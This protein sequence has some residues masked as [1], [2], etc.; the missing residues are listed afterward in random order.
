MNDSYDL[1][2]LGTP[3]QAYEKLD[4]LAKELQQKEQEAKKFNELE[5]LFELQISKYPE[6]GETKT[7]LRY[8]SS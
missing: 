1:L 6:I 4:D 7:E 5:E 2:L 8:N 3:N